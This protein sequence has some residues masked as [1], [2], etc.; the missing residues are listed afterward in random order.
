MEG[1]IAGFAY[2]ATT[3]VVGQPFDTIKTLQQAST[4][5]S[6]KSEPLIHVTRN[7]YNTSGIAGFYRGGIPLLIGGGLIRSAQFGVYNNALSFLQNLREDSLQKHERF[8]GIIDPQVVLAGFA[9]GIGRAIAESPFEYMKVR[10]Q[11]KE[12]IKINNLFKGSGV[13]IFRNSILFS[14]FMIYIDIS[15]QLGGLPPFLTGGI[16]SCMAWL[17]IWPLD[18]AKSR[19]QSGYFDSQKGLF[20]ILRSLYKGG[21]LYAGVIPGLTR[22]F[23]ANGISM[24]VYKKVENFIAEKY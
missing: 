8:G 9:G 15:K 11:V 19:I 13:T 6:T 17:T 24:V 4:L 12:K 14:S 21:N 5:S 10:Q 22:S 20:G 1:F 18:V 3:V 16:C 2:G 7:L 23:I